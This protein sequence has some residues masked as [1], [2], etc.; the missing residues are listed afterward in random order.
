M[1]TAN[2][3][4][5]LISRARGLGLSVHLT[6]PFYDIDVDADLSQLAE[7]L[8]HS[9]GKARRTAEWLAKRAKPQAATERSQ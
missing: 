3:L 9:P 7:E 8:R 5:A 6:E 4:P 2:A 1:V